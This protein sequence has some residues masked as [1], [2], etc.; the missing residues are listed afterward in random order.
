MDM[1]SIVD[2]LQYE[3]YLAEKEMLDNVTIYQAKL[4]SP[5]LTEAGTIVLQEAMKDTIMKYIRKIASGTQNAWNNFKQSVIDKGINKYYE[6]NKK[7]FETDF[8]MKPPKDFTLPLLEEY[9]KF[10]SNTTITAY[11]E[12][13]NKDLESVDSFL[14]AQLRSYAG[15]LESGKKIKQIAEEKV[16]KKASG[17]ENIGRDKMKEI[18]QFAAVDYKRVTDRLITNIKN[19]N[20]S[21][22][23]IESLLKM[24]QSVNGVKKES[25]QL[26]DT[27]RHY[28][29]EE[30]ESNT[31]PN[32]NTTSNN[33]KENQSKSFQD[34]NS[35]PKN[36]EQKEK[37]NQLDN[38][39]KVY[40][41]ACTSV[42]SEQLSITNKV[43]V[44]CFRMMTEYVKLQQKKENTTSKENDTSNDN[45]EDTS[46]TQVKL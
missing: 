43:V 37:Q 38:I 13:M 20:S 2:D 28:F 3:S 26:E 45:K 40:F 8:V 19:L 30:G 33:E 7:W 42:I 46:A 36:D 9:N 24:S 6:N 5:I 44:S 4:M 34:A 11:S 29:N 25:Y 14:K 21:S 1:E 31:E 22:R 41:S 18:V 12:A 32:Q 39:A 27:M 10:I 35:N 23:T 16:F 15:E 17:Q